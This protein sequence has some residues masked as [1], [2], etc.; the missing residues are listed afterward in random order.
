[1]LSYDDYKATLL[2]F[3]PKMQVKREQKLGLPMGTSEK[4]EQFK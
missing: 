3:Q 2:K 1:M 4:Y